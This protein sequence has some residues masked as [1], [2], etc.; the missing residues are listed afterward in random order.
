VLEVLLLFTPLSGFSYR[1]NKV[2]LIYNYDTSCGAFH[3]L[4]TY[5]LSQLWLLPPLEMAPRNPA[6]HAN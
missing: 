1:F 6:C 2:I 4:A 5:V 3:F